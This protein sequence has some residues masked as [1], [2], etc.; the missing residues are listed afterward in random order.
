MKKRKPHVHK[1]FDESK[2]TDAERTYFKQA[3]GKERELILKGCPVVIR[4]LVD[5]SV[6]E[7]NMENVYVPDYDYEALARALL[8][9]IREFYLDEEHVRAYEE[10]RA[11]Q[12]FE[13]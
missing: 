7:F 11:K 4:S 5:E 2:L 13:K 9:S 3:S 12:S 10:W 1:P 6:Y 8:P